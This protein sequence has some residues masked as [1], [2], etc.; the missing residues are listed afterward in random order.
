MTLISYWIG[1]IIPIN[2][3]EVILNRDLRVIDVITFFVLLLVLLNFCEYLCELLITFGS[4]ILSSSKRDWIS[5]LGKFDCFILLAIV[6][7]MALEFASVCFPTD[8]SCVYALNQDVH[9]V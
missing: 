4:E 6:L 2:V 1:E 8:I 5:F 7:M 9:F 3:S